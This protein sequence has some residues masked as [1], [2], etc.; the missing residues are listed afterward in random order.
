MISSFKAYNDVHHLFTSRDHILLAVSG[1]IDSMVMLHLFQKAGLACGVAH[2]NFGLRAEAS[3]GD[4]ALVRI[5]AE[6]A[7]FSFHV[8]HFDTKLYAEREGV[9]VQMAARTLR[10]DWFYELSDTYGYTRIAV[11]HNH[12]DLLETVMIN[13]GRGTGIHGITGI[14]PVQGRIIR[15]LLFADRNEIVEYARTEGISWRDDASNAEDVYQRNFIRHHLLPCFEEVFPSFRN[16]MG[17]NVQ[18]FGEARLLYDQAV[19]SHKY[20]MMHREGST[21][22]IALP[23]LLGSIAPRTLLYEMIKEFGFGP[24]RLDDIYRALFD[25]ASGACFLS[26]THR[27]IRDREFL[28]IAPL[29]EPDKGRYYIESG[30]NV[31]HTPLTLQLSIGVRPDD[32]VPKGNPLTAELDADLLEF[33]LTIRHWQQGDYFV[34]LGL[35]GMMKVSDFY[36][37]RKLS[38]IQKEQ[39]WIILS[40]EKVV[41]MVDRRIDDRFKVTQ[42]TRNMLTINH[43][44]E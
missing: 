32:F 20:M 16:T 33:P 29:A 3:D 17:R 5:E 13:L 40:G 4:E 1:G 14:K 22:F 10:Y 41:W 11:A 35:G 25:A 19:E 18:R 6:K 23:S 43:I 42:N 26:R 37:N 39:A 36:I 31:V 15:P 9:S 34:P 44:S 27:L 7:A 28:M 30:D 24:S 2:C 21:V 38:L 12:D 8:R